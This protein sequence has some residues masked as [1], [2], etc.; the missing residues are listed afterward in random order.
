M[1]NGMCQEPFFILLVFCC[2]AAK[3]QLAL[4]VVIFMLLQGLKVTAR[5]N[6]KVFSHCCRGQLTFLKKNK[7]A[8][9]VVPREFIN[10]KIQPSWSAVSMI[11]SFFLNFVACTRIALEQICF[12]RGKLTVDCGQVNYRS[13][14]LRPP[15]IDLISV[16]CL[17]ALF[18]W[19]CF[20]LCPTRLRRDQSRPFLD[21]LIRISQSLVNSFL[22]LG[23]LHWFPLRQSDFYEP[24]VFT[25]RWS[26]NFVINVV[27]ERERWRLRFHLVS[28][29]LCILLYGGWIEFEQIITKQ[30][31]AEYY[32]NFYSACFSYKF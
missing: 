23:K 11:V 15:W 17:G 16:Q 7:M 28:T 18:V 8:N 24:S 14:C 5:W 31:T 27:L 20:E 25:Y 30:L 29:S 22:Y 1:V 12:Q 2:R 19:P 13:I 6:S 32:I 26:L 4:A 21:F 3:N 9:L 10:Y